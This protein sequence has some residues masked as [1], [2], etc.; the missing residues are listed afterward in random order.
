MFGDLSAI[1]FGKQ[2]FSMFP[3]IICVPRPINK[4]LKQKPPSK[5]CINFIKCTIVQSWELFFCFIFCYIHSKN[6]FKHKDSTKMWCTPMRIF[7]CILYFILNFSSI[8]FQGMISCGCVPISHNI[9]T[10]FT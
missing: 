6:S 5:A 8:F 7:C 1:N 4:I 2:N 9:I 3:I 10:A